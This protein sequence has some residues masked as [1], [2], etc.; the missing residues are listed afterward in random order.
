MTSKAFPEPERYF[1]IKEEE[2]A[3]LKRLI[4][5]DNQ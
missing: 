3:E 4:A 2:L 5:E 1:G